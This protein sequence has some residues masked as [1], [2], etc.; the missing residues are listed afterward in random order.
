MLKDPVRQTIVLFR[1][2]A[3]T[4]RWKA[5]GIVRGSWTKASFDRAKGTVRDP[6][7]DRP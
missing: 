2:I 6:T 4:V 5:G 7:R 3:G 1:G